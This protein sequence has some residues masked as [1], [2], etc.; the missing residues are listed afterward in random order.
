[1]S[2]NN[3]FNRLYL[4]YGKS[5]SFGIWNL[6][7]LTARESTSRFWLKSENRKNTFTQRWY[8]EF[9]SNFLKTAWGNPNWSKIEW[10]KFAWWFQIRKK[11]MWMSCGAHTSWFFIGFIDFQIK[12]FW[13]NYFI[14][15]KLLLFNEKP[16]F[17]TFVWNIFKEH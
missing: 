17:I 2:N 1:M 9:F 11:L 5:H 3:Y 10:T 13:R 7:Y 6:S 14:F 15:F 8:L 12:K 4:V 16:K